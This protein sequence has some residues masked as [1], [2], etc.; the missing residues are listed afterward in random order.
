MRLYK[1]NDLKVI[2]KVVSVNN[3]I[4]KEV[5]EAIFSQYYQ[6]V[7]EVIAEQNRDDIINFK[8]VLLHNFGKLYISD[9]KK[10][11][12]HNSIQ[13]YKNKKYGES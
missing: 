13:D 10:V 6:K 12:I 11:K 3:N 4:P 7:N 8:T 9:R 1:N 5:V 2:L